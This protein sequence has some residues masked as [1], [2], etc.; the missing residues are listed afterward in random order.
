MADSFGDTPGSSKGTSGT[1]DLGADLAAGTVEAPDWFK[2]YFRATMLDTFMTTPDV[3]VTWIL[4]Q[5]ALRGVPVSISQISGFSGFTARYASVGT[6]Q[7]T[8]SAAYTDLATVGPT[9][10]GLA[11]GNYV[12]FFGATTQTA[13]AAQA[14]MSVQ[15]NSTGAQDSDGTFAAVTT[16]T[17]ISRAFVVPL[18]ADDNNTLTAKYHSNGVSNS[19]FALRWIIALKYGN[20]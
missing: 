3:F 5:I 12:V 11:N 2:T 14:W 16:G 8:T 19:D 18:T 6:T 4:D 1:L 17:S 13:G 20:L 10:T 7:G 15:I 9:L